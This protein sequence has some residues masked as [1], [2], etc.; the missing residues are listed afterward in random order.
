M[1]FNGSGVFVRLYNWVNDAAANIKIRADRMDNEMDGMAVGLSTCITKD[2]QTTIT[3]NLPMAGFRHTGIGNAAA[4]NDY[5]AFGQVQDGKAAWADGGGTADAITAAYSI[6]VTAL[7]D[8]QLCY[9]RASAANAT[10][11]PTFSPNGLT[12]RTIVK[13]G[14]QALA[15]GDIAGDGHELELRYD[16][17]NTRWEL[18]NPRGP[19]TAA[20]AAAPA[21]IQFAEDTD[22]GTHKVTLQAPAALA[23]DTTVVLPT[24]S[25]TLVGSL[26]IKSI[27]DGRLTLTSGTPVTTSDVTGAT[28]VYYTPYIG[29]QIG[30]YTGSAWVSYTFAEL[31]LALGTLTSGLPYD[32]FLDYNDG[33]PQLAMTAWTNDTTRATALVRQDGI[34]VKTGDTQ[35]RYLGTFYTT[36]TTTTEDSAANRYLKNY[37]N[38]VDCQVGPGVFTTT[39]TTT[40]TSV[41]EINSETRRNFLTIEG[42]LVE[43]NSGGWAFNS[44]S[45]NNFFAVGID[46]TTTRTL[47]GVTAGTAGGPVSA[48]GYFNL[49][50]GLHYVTFLGAV[51]AGTG[52]YRVG[53]L[54]VTGCMAKVTH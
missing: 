51:S 23:A 29:N 52:N 30:L 54:E 18:M 32:V 43:V 45:N 36:S 11:T 10:T 21:S 44:A 20:S 22:N 12:A 28:S 27:A 38:R 26:D 19:F 34:L 47:I 42:E 53:A 41:V 35:Q 7:V 48:P 9:V 15:A 6:P 17:S 2:G 37:Y 3:A 16:L 25:A 46:G 13:N 24:Y 14:G 8:G 39:R 5:A 50:E 33:T 40:S 49:A 31:S 1:A 4:R